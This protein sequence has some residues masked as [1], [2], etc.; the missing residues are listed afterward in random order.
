[1]APETLQESIPLVDLE[2]HLKFEC[3]KDA[4]AA[5]TTSLEQY[6][7]VLVRDSRVSAADSDAFVDLMERYFEQSRDAKLTDA[8]PEFYHQVGATPDHTER[9]RDN[10]SIAASLE[11]EH[12]PKS[13]PAARDKDPK[14][15]F[16]WRVGPRPEQTEFPQLNAPQVIPNAFKEEWAA[17]MDA[18]GTK[19]LDT[20]RSVA[21]LLAVGLGLQ[22]DSITSLMDG[23]AH[24]LAPTGTDLERYGAEVGRTLAGYHYDISLLSL[25]GRARYPGLFIW[26]RDGRRIP[27]VM[28]HGTLLVQS[29]IQ[30]E[31]LTAGRIMRGMH[32]VVVSEETAAA[33]RTANKRSKWRVSSTL[34][35]HVH[36]DRRL[37]PLIKN[38]GMEAKYTDIKAGELVANE[39]KE[40][41]LA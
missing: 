19:L 35:A 8:R 30:L 1:M 6:G 39:L 18:W 11:A 41:E 21:Q 27:V 37:A 5:L 2:V 38:N 9:P 25:H 26:T 12:R 32:E 20:S 36:S 15:R 33:A 40:L 3:T 24:L 22:E 14:W 34:F 13:D 16:F 4:A 23:G 31:N 28:P 29:G 10:S 7:A 17:V